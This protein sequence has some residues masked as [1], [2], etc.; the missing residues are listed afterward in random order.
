MTEAMRNQHMNLHRN[1]IR[2]IRQI[3]IDSI[4]LRRQLREE[5]S[6]KVRNS[7]IWIFDALGHLTQLALHLDHTVQNQVR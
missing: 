3:I 1:T 5:E 6:R 2:T 4:F 7:L